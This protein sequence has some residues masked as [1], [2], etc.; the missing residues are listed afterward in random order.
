MTGASGFIG[1]HVVEAAARRGHEVVALVLRM[2][3]NGSRLVS[4]FWGVSRAVLWRLK[5]VH[6][7]TLIW[8]SLP[9]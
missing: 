3:S 4:R 2:P 5:A 1:R 9:A 7:M 6:E 8:N